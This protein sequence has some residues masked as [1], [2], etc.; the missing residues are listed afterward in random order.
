MLIANHESVYH[1]KT[2][3]SKSYYKPMQRYV[4]II[5]NKFDHFVDITL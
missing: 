4:R 2:E 5:N 3:E 1:W